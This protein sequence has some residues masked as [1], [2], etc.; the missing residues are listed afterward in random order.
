MNILLICMAS[1]F[2]CNLHVFNISSPDLSSSFRFPP[3]YWISVVGCTQ[4][5]QIKYVQYQPHFSFLS[6]QSSSQ[7]NSLYSPIQLVSSSSVCLSQNIFLTPF[8]IYSQTIT[9][10]MSCILIFR[11]MAL[12]LSVVSFQYRPFKWSL[13]FQALFFSI[14]ITF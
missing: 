5:L 12:P 9:C 10:K 6:S 2:D 14:A 13:C 7:H 1:T 8:C 3:A 11:F 4:D